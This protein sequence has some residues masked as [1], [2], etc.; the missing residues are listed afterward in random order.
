MPT[1][2]RGGRLGIG[3]MTKSSDVST[4]SGVDDPRWRMNDSYLHLRLGSRTVP[5]AINPSNW[6]GSELH[7]LERL[8]ILAVRSR[9]PQRTDESGR[10]K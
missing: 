1:D 8:A 9:S 3:S 10:P 4:I 2:R 7:P 6:Y 5:R